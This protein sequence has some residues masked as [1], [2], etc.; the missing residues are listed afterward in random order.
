M[1]NKIQEK[2]K[3]PPMTCYPLQTQKFSSQFWN[4][5]EIPSPSVVT[6]FQKI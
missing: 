5:Q 2:R 1:E 4:H 6:W 3:E